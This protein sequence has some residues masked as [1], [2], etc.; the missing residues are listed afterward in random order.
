MNDPHLGKP[1][2]GGFIAS[3][4]LLTG[5]KTNPLAAGISSH[6]ISPI[7]LYDI[8]HRRQLVD[9]FVFL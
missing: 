2:W 4:G 5:R 7:I 8:V 9:V 6:K 3:G 1:I